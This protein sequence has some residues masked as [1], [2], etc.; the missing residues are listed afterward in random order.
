MPS[1]GGNVTK[2]ELESYSGVKISLMSLD[3][4]NAQ[5]GGTVTG[6][7]SFEWSLSWDSRGITGIS[8]SEFGIQTEEEFVNMS[9]IEKANIAADYNRSCPD[10]A[11]FE[12]ISLG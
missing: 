10:C 1:I 9:Q 6:G 12:V 3:N 2:Q 5:T 7:G 4:G 11:S 8:W